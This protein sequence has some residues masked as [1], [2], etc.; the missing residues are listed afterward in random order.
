MTILLL[1]STKEA[2]YLHQGSNL[3]L[4]ILPMK[5]QSE[6]MLY[7]H[8]MSIFFWI[9]CFRNMGRK[10]LQINVTLHS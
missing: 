6:Y 2:Y 7:L 9:H 3:F 10:Q 1:R 8:L 5:F 4:I